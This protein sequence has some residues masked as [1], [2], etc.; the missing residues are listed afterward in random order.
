M[1]DDVGHKKWNTGRS[2]D[3]RCAGCVF[4][5]A[6]HIPDH[7]PPIPTNLWE[8]PVTEQ[9]AIEAALDEVV[10]KV[11][12]LVMKDDNRLAAIVASAFLRTRPDLAKTLGIGDL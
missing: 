8:L 4:L 2:R 12:Q 5:G 11:N 7:V 10:E 9:K 6:P 1:T 3:P